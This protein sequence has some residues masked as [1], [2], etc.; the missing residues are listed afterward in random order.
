MADIPAPLVRA[1][2]FRKP[3]GEKEVNVKTAR[4][5]RATRAQPGSPGGKNTLPK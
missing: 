5:G 4:A 1:A 2:F 3:Q